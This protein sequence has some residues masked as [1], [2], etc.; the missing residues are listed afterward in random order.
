MQH[1]RLTDCKYY[2]NEITSESGRIDVVVELFDILFEALEAALQVVHAL[3]KRLIATRTRT[4]TRTTC[5]RT[6]RPRLVAA[7]YATGALGAGVSLSTLWCRRA[8]LL[9]VLLLTFLTAVGGGGGL[10]VVVEVF[11][12][13]LV[14]VVVVVVVVDNVVVVVE[15]LSYGAVVFAAAAAAAAVG[16]VVVVDEYG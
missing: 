2:L 13:A 16:G 14:A 15:Y 10:V 11:K 3:Q 4:R 7:A 5:A 9:L 8:L 6:N 12:D 1:T